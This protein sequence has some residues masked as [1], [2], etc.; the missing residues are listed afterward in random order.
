MSQHSARV[1]HEGPVIPLIERLSRAVGGAHSPQELG[2]LHL[3][4]SAE[5]KALQ[6]IKTKISLRIR[7]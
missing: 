4:S 5:Y 6:E 7:S 3:H 2:Q 1:P